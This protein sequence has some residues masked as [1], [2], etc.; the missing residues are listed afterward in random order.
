MLA[1]G[2]IKT[3]LDARLRG[4]Y[5]INSAWKAVELAMNCVSHTSNKRPNMSEVVRGLKDCL[6]SELARTNFN[7]VTESTDSVIY[8]MNVTTECSP[9]GSSVGCILQISSNYDIP[10]MAQVEVEDL[11]IQLEESLELSN[12]EEGVKLIG[13]ALT[14]L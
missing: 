2:D 5:D 14:K 6:E 11:V 13:E 9:L 8:S 12:M 1:R 3:I 4:D 7:R 10:A